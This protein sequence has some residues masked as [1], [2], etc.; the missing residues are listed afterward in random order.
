[1]ADPCFLQFVPWKIKL[2]TQETVFQVLSLFPNYKFEELSM[3]LAVPFYKQST[4]P[5]RRCL[6]KSF[7]WMVAFFKNL[8]WSYKYVVG[9]GEKSQGALTPSERA[10]QCCSGKYRCVWILKMLLF[11]SKIDPNPAAGCLV[12]REEQI[13]L[14]C[15]DFYEFTELGFVGNN[16][17]LLA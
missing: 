13:S 5:T 8:E 7:F 16:C 11:V 3:V 14:F 17:G 12:L 15:P 10:G 9:W 4:F 2:E 1:M 6:F